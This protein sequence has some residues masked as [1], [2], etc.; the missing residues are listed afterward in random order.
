MSWNA[1]HQGLDMREF[2]LI[3]RGPQ[4]AVKGVYSVRILDLIVFTHLLPL[5]SPSPRGY[6]PSPRR[7]RLIQP[8]G[9]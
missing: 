6:N 2:G 1:A 4:I 8:V 3:V 9:T 5:S 7:G